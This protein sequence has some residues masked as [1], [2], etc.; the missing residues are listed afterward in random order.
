MVDAIG[1]WLE[2]DWLVIPRMATT[3]GLLNALGFCLLGL[4]A[5]IVEFSAEHTEKTGKYR[6]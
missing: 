3:H 2:Q 4:L 5:W 1:D 6:L